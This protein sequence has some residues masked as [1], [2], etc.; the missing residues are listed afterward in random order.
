ML[1]SWWWYQREQLGLTELAASDTWTT[2]QRRNETEKGTILRTAAGYIRFEM[3]FGNEQN[4]VP[5]SSS[6]CR[7]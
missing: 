4:R 7:R 2:Q 1:R 6:R 5:R 3:K